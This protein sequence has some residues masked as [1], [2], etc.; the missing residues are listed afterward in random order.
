TWV[1]TD[2]LANSLR[3]LRR[4]GVV[5]PLGAGT[6]SQRQ[7]APPRLPDLSVPRG[8]GAA[9]RPQPEHLGPIPPALRRDEKIMLDI[10]LDRRTVYERNWVFVPVG[11]Y[12]ASYE[13][14]ERSSLRLL[15]SCSSLFRA[16]GAG[17]PVLQRL[18]RR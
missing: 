11:V 7:S 17:E 12:D 15:Q 4:G 8:R 5:R 16:D 10:P 6:S 1:S 13:P 3:P 2:A 9:S 18:L 14:L